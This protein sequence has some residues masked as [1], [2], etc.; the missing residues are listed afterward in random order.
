M[1]QDSQ[2]RGAE[3]LCKIN[4]FAEAA[5]L[6]GNYANSGKYPSEK[7]LGP[8]S[9][10][11]LLFKNRSDSP[12]L[13]HPPPGKSHAIRCPLSGATLCFLPFRDWTEKCALKIKI[14]FH[15]QDPDI[16]FVSKD[17]RRSTKTS[18]G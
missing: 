11:D 16:S 8:P 1:A 10:P 12:T 9:S 14:S 2:A 15:M 7:V 5:T 3:Q 13:F 6:T 17:R 18:G 4:I